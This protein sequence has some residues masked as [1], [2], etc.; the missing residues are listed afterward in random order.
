MHQNLLEK[1][2]MIHAN[3]LCDMSENHISTS[4]VNMDQK[5]IPIMAVM[6]NN[7]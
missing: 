5:S 6:A 2:W 3:G 1:I 4:P 7:K